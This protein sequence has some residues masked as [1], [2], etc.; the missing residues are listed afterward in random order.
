MSMFD[1]NEDKKYAVYFGTRN[2]RL[3]EVGR[4]RCTTAELQAKI[5]E[6]LLGHGPVEAY[7][8]DG[9]T[10]DFKRDPENPWMCITEV[11]TRHKILKFREIS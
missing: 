10:H 7:L 1:A 4:Y 11:N 6:T 3:W 9:I 2:G 8:S 5:E